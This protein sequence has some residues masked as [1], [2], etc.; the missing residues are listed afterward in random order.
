MR[1]R[2]RSYIVF[3]G[4]LFVSFM[5]G[6]SLLKIKNPAIYQNCE[7]LDISKESIALFS[8]DWDLIND[9]YFTALDIL[10]NDKENNEVITFLINGL[11]Q[12][13]ND[14]FINFHLPPGKYILRNMASANSTSTGVSG[15]T[16]SGE[17]PINSAFE[18]GANEIIYLG[19][20]DINNTGKTNVDEL[21][22]NEILRTFTNQGK[23]KII[24]TTIIEINDHFNNDIELFKDGYPCLSDYKIK[25]K[26]LPPWKR[27]S[28]EGMK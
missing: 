24:G 19:H 27:Q 25:N 3:L 12:V 9:Y 2:Y 18:I 14:H 4:I 22:D 13:G 15:Y 23:T 20:I 8:I 10:Q 17:M 7:T 5:P 11:Y 1:F 21:A 28:E 26:T 16:Q 6:C